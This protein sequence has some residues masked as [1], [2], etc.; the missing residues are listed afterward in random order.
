M[1]QNIKVDSPSKLQEQLRFFVS[2]KLG[3]NLF[4]LWWLKPKFNVV[5]SLILKIPETLIKVLGGDLIDF[6]EEFLKIYTILI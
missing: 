4:S 5:R 2:W 1:Q 6:S 3:L